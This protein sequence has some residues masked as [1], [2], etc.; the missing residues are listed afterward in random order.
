MQDCDEAMTAHPII[1]AIPVRNAIEWTMPLV[2]S[3]LDNDEAD[4]VWLFD[5][6]STDGTTQWANELAAADCRFTVTHRPRAR[7]YAMWNEMVARATTQDRLNRAHNTSSSKDTQPSIQTQSSISMQPSINTES[8]LAIL[9]NDIVLPAGALRTL[10]SVMTQAT[11]EEGG[12]YD[13]AFVD[14]SRNIAELHNPR[15]VAVQWPQKSG[16]A[17]M[18]RVP[19]WQGQPFAVDPG[20]R[21]YWGDDDLARRAQARGGRLCI[22]EGLNIFHAVSATPY[23]GDKAADIEHDREYFDRI[24]R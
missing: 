9:N 19:F 15:P 13:R 21:I 10:S 5:N 3:L 11:S 8:M 4:Q 20:L 1:A 22:V 24:W 18:L 6:G 23:S 14:E 2:T 16:A 12:P 17:M 7:L